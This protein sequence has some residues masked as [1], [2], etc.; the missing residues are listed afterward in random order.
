M[1]G[2][3]GASMP[4][5]HADND[6]LEV[7]NG[8]QTYAEYAAQFSTWAVRAC[9]RACVGHGVCARVCVRARVCVCVCVCARVCVC[10]CVRARV[11]AYRQILASPLIL[12][13]DI[14]SMTPECAH[15]HTRACPRALAYVTCRC[16]AIVANAEVIAVNQD[17][18]GIRAKLVLQW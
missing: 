4:R 7:C 2:V 17:A 1:R 10:V 14:R 15:N 11:R 6:M 16:L 13:N 18:L 3:A 12:G 5:R 8:G 9:V